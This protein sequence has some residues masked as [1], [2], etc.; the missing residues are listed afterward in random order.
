MTVMRCRPIRGT[1][2]PPPT[3]SRSVPAGS[4]CLSVLVATVV[5]LA[6]C[7]TTGPPEFLK[8][9]DSNYGQI[10][11]VRLL[12]VH[13]ATPPRE[14]WQPGGTAPLHLT[15]SNDGATEVTLTGIS[16]PGA[17]RVVHEAAG[18]ATET[19]RIPA[20]PGETVSLQENDTERMALEGLTERLRSGL[21]IPVTFALDTGESVTLAVPAQIS[22]EPAR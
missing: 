7:G 14:G 15:I 9:R 11:D 8:T 21:T 19:V 16:S 5:T 3:A 6:G 20:E 4:R 1:R 2:R 18:G 17:A 10:G 22:D 12:H 13:V